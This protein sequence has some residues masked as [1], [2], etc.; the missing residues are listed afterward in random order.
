MHI[1]A[2]ITNK[3]KIIRSMIVSAAFGIII[4]LPAMMRLYG[5]TGRASRPFMHSF[6]GGW[7]KTDKWYSVPAIG[8]SSI[9]P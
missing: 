1:Q 8:F 6:G 3:E 4:S 2:N 5:C 7:M 9:G